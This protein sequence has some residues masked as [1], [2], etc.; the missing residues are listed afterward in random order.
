MEGAGLTQRVAHRRWMSF[1]SYKNSFEDTCQSCFIFNFFLLSKKHI[2]IKDLEKVEIFLFPLFLLPKKFVFMLICFFF[3][4][5]LIDF[6]ESKEGRK[7]ESE[8]ETWICCSTYFGIHS[9]ILVHALT[10][11][12]TLAYQDDALTHQANQSIYPLAIFPANNICYQS[13][14]ITMK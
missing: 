3:K 1:Q 4:K 10:R 12:W 6:R 13:Y 14:T 8:K 2:V 11:D 5:N 7:R 9:F